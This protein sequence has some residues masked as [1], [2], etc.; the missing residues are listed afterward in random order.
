MRS[1]SCGL[2][3]YNNDRLEIISLLS[4][5]CECSDISD[6]VIIDNSPEPV[7]T[8]NDISEKIS[9]IHRPENIGFGRAHNLAFTKIRQKSKF[10]LIINPDICVSAHSISSLLDKLELD[11][12]ISGAMPRI[13]YR[14]G[15][16]QNLCKQLPS[17]L[18]LLI[19]RIAGRN[20]SVKLFPKYELEYKDKFIYSP[21]ISGCFMIIRSE[22]FE[23]LGGFDESYFMYMEDIDLSRRLWRL[24]PLICY[25]D[26]R[27]KHGYAAGSYKLSRLLLIHV[28]SALIYFKKWGFFY[29][30]ERMAI[31]RRA[32]E[33]NFLRKV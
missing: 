28:K 5:I 32:D 27:V 9:Y 8:D 13:T 3:L 2:V 29:D 4:N 11:T 30:A 10:H 18:N 1:L 24:G 26:V 25:T 22:F 19:R 17:A 31:N 16:D 20:F 23:K 14:N 33:M 12:L 15:A 6:V 7:L 21:T